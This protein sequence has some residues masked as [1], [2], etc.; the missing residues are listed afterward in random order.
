MSAR[1]ERI[2]V[3]GAGLM[4]RGIAQSLAL[5]GW[6]PVIVDRLPELTEKAL[7][8][9]ETSLTDAVVAGRLT[10]ADARGAVDRIRTSDDLASVCSSADVVL[11]AVPEQ[12]PV[13]HTVWREISEAARDDA[14]LAT[15]TSALD[16]DAIAVAVAA[17]ERFLGIHWYNPAQLVPGI[18]IVPGSMTG[19][20]TVTRALA[21]MI[22]AGKKPIVVANRPGFVGNR[23][24]FALIAEAFR[25][26]EEGVATAESI[27]E[28]AR[29]TFGMRLGDFG[30]IRLAD[31]GGL[32][33]YVSILTYLTETLGERFA[34]P[35]LL[36][37]LV[38]RGDL[39][40][41]SGRGVFSYANGEGAALSAERDSALAR[42]LE[43]LH[44]P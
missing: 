32:D 9:I 37:E 39:G 13:K 11:E 36:R 24:Q 10:D 16:I 14:L 1:E 41:K 22:A 26:L 44:H 5:G 34:V 27:D 3:I 2:C 28:I 42:R 29:S 23:L 38:E 19:A 25:C 18:E 8:D 12:L 35:P 43:H 30:P 17:P 6:S 20:E 31:L 33:T 15:N 21:L 4:G 7:L 40:V